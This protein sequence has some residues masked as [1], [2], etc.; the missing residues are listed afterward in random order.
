MPA[1]DLTAPHASARVGAIHSQIVV[2]EPTAVSVLDSE[3]IVVRPEPDLVATLGGAQW[4]DRLPK[5]LQ[6]RIV[7]AFENVGRIRSVGRP[8]ERI[9]ADYDLVIDIR[10]FQISL[11]PS[12][13]GEVEL[14]VKIVSEANGRILAGRIFHAS[15]PAAGSMDRRRWRRSTPPSRTSPCR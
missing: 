1:F 15:A 7:Q 13:A 9:A 4:M 3:R 2:P 10:K 5:L 12:P 14:A 8:G 6:A 11:T